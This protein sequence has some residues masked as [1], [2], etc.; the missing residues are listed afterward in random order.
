MTI[1]PGETTTRLA[2]IAAIRREA[3]DILSFSL[4]PT[5]VSKLPP[6]AAGAHIDLHIAPDH[7]RQYSRANNTVLSA[8]APLRWVE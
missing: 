5:G 2:E 1:V 7:V 6:F 8:I 4:A 3:I